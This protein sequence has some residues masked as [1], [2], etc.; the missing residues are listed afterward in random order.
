MG[1]SDFDAESHAGSGLPTPCVRVTF[2]SPRGRERKPA[3]DL[4]AQMRRKEGSPC[5]VGM[6]T[7]TDSS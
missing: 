1:A 4:V 6:A 2:L 3:R 5:G 7:N